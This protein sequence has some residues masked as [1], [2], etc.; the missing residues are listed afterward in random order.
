LRKLIHE[1]HPHIYGDVK[2][3]DEEEVKKN[4]EQLKLKE[5]NKSA[6]ACRNLYR[7]W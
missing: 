4:W 2:V 5:G 1:R 7:R 3:A 6:L